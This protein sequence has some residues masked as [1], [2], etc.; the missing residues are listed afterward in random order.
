MHPTIRLEVFA[1]TTKPIFC[2]N[3]QRVN[4]KIIVYYQIDYTASTLICW[5]FFRVFISV[6]DNDDDVCALSLAWEAY[7][8]AEIQ[9]NGPSVW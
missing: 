4:R 1:P 8:F 6:L 2:I 9:G 7:K 3:R 5:G